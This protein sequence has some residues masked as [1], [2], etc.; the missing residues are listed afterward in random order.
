MQP[1]IEILIGAPVV[2][3]EAAALRDLVSSL[4]APALVLVNFEIVSRDTSRQI[5]FLVVTS[6]RAELIELKEITA[7]VKGGTN[8]PWQI[9]T[10]RGLF[11]PYTGP[12]PW[13]QARDAKFA[14]SDAM[15]AF[16]KRGAVPPPTDKY[17]FKQIDAC[18]A[19]YP[20]IESGSDLSPGD[21]K[22][23]IK[24]FPNV[25]Q[26][27]NSIPLPLR[28]SWGMADWRI[29]ASQY[30]NLKQVTLQSAIDASV[31]T[32]HLRL[33]EFGIRLKEQRIAPLL[34]ATP[35]EMA[36]ENLITELSSAQDVLLLGRSGL[37]KSFHLEHYRRRCVE[38]GDVPILLNAGHYRGDLNR[39]I[40]KTIGPYTS[41]TPAEIL[42]ASKRVGRK[43]VL[44]VDDWNKCA[45]S[46]HGDLSNDLASFQVRYHTRIVT[47]SQGR[48]I[49]PFFTKFKSVDLA[50]L[51]N[52]H[53]K[54]IFGFHA[55]AG[56][57]PR[58]FGFSDA[59]S[60][61]FDLSVAG[62]CCRNGSF[63]ATR[64]EL[65]DGYTRLILPSAASRAI[66]R[67]LAW[68]MGESFRPFLSA[69]EYERMTEGFA[70]ELG[71]PV[72]VVEEVLK[73]GLLFIEADAVAFEHDLLKDFFRAEYMLRGDAYQVLIDRLLEPKY[74]ELAE[75][76]IP[77]ITNESTLRGCLSYADPRLLS[78]GLRGGLGRRAQNIIR[79]QCRDLLLRTRDTLPHVKVEA[80]VGES[81][82]GRKF[83]SSAHTD[84]GSSAST[85][86]CRLCS[87]IAR[88]LDDSELRDAFLELLEVGE[89]AL[90]SASDQAAKA[91]GLKPLSVWRE[92][93]RHNV[94]C[95]HNG[96]IHLLLLLCVEFREIS[97]LGKSS[98]P[99]TF[100]NVLLQRV[101]TNSS[102]S[103]VQLLLI[104]AL[105]YSE[106]VNVEDAA[107]L[108][109]Q[110]WSSGVYI[111]QME[112]LDFLHSNARAICQQGPQA[113]TRIIELMDSLD[114]SQ[115]LFLSTQWLETR[116]SFTGFDCGLTTD[117]AVAE[118]R[119]ILAMA[120]KGD[121]PLWELERNHDP[122]STFEQ[123][124]GSY[125]SSALGKVFE[126]VFQGVYFEAY[127][128]LTPSERQQLLTLA[129]KDRRSHL[130]QAWYLQELR[131][132]GIEGA[133]DILTRLGSGVDGDAFCPQETIETFV[134]AN[135]A[136]AA[137]SGEPLR[138][139]DVSSPDHRTWAIIGELIFWLNRADGANRTARIEAL[140]AELLD[141]PGA[142]PDALH[143]LGSGYLGRQQTSPLSLLLAKYCDDLRAVL[144]RCLEHEGRLTSAF[145]G[146]QHRQRE[147]FSWVISTL[148][149]IGDGES[150]EKL[151]VWT[152]HPVYG[153]PAICAIEK[154][155]RRGV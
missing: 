143:H 48:P 96:P 22:A 133:T 51:R 123:F 78:L 100:E 3:S 30:L 130:F 9:E 10:S 12:N 50:P 35:G 118:Y 16:A 148:A 124:V 109:S 21:F 27:L 23:W 37:G 18:V 65:Y 64:W 49:Q 116:A 131:K 85:Y 151:R 43:L 122:T 73:S 121:D 94:L 154:I 106:S 91:Q 1:T 147:L 28:S 110:A 32:A 105:R 141:L 71:A 79:Q 113:E 150:I 60:T 120:D 53:K 69:A 39:A 63:P 152:E 82:D 155:R 134:I 46:L 54:Q 104:S 115:N 114:V 88:H 140:I 4:V 117:D 45:A 98:R 146:V 153:K 128:L 84:V 107:Q 52:D 74:A 38:S 6:Q 7:P 33:E 55:A 2:G 36:G 101:R 24:S 87:V 61:A 40:H 83:V 138:Y 80:V 66:A 25:I 89:W 111:I 102:G 119:R 127:E 72:T 129:L 99:S 14:L 93:I 19:V 125:A 15:Q 112:A 56:E 31:F 62:R 58:D 142:V 135:E 77:N 145:R 75:F 34:E 59:F 57:T 149:E 20:R 136:W 17:F 41:L 139:T 97:R 42:D 132:L 95:Q 29:F 86:E 8:G 81:E 126:D 108:F 44:I 70:S 11:V 26:G 67:H 5:D 103:L 13:V 68:F 144:N 137:V 47:A 92:L 76:V 90:R